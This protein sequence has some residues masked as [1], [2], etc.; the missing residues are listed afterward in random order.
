MRDIFLREN[1]L[2][3]L[4]TWVRGHPYHRQKWNNPIL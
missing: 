4:T 3:I 1:I 2:E